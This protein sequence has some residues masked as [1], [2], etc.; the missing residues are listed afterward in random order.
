VGVSEDYLWGLQYMISDL[1]EVGIWVVALMLVHEGLARRKQIN[2]SGLARGIHFIG[3]VIII[4]GA[5]F[6]YWNAQGLQQL[7]GV[8]QMPPVAPQTAVQA[9]EL[10]KLPLPQRKVM[11]IQL[12]KAAYVGGGAPIDVVTDEGLWIPYSPSTD[13]VDARDR[14]ISMNA[15]VNFRRQELIDGAH[16]AERHSRHWLLSLIVVFCTGLVAGRTKG[17]RLDLIFRMK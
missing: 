15:E 6:W 7:A 9:N 8:L 17:A 12:A 11:S 4:I 5:G 13:D 14:Q 3:A 10:N 16:I 2:R 1:F